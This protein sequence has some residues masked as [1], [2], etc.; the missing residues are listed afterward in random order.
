MRY[1]LLMIVPLCI[2][3]PGEQARGEINLKIKQKKF[4]QSLFNERRYF[5]CI[6]ETRRLINLNAKDDAPHKYDFFI[7]VNYYYGHQYRSVIHNITKKNKD[8]YNLS[9]SILLSQSFLR[10]GMFSQAGY[11]LKDIHYGNVD[12]EGRYD[13]LLR[14][15]EP[16]LYTANFKESLAEVERSK[17]FFSEKKKIELLYSE[18]EKYDK[19]RLK[20]K[21]LSVTLSAIIPGSGQIYSG[22][23]LDG[24]L[25]FIGVAATA[26]S[27][28]FLYDYGENE[29]AYTMIFFSALFYGG[30]IYGAYNSANSANV[31]LQ[32]EFLTAMKDR[33]IHSYNPGKEVKR[34]GIFK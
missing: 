27:A 4:V 18:I 24:I 14:K 20:S 22:K 21:A 30:N 8:K 15:L 6:S 2:F 25:S 32:R 34:M 5:D 23:Y 7:N 33:F 10:L 28:Y 12:K 19:I 31:M 1:L 9:D 3:F 26:A 13:V 16:L 29:L 17:R 11:V